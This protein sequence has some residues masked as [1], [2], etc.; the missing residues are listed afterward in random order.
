MAVNRFDQ[1]RNMLWRRKL[2]DAVAQIE[3]VRRARAL[4]VG[5]RLAETV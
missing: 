3:D 5:M 2:A 4:G 1:R